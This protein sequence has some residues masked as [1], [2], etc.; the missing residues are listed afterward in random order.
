[1]KEPTLV[2]GYIMPTELWAQNICIKPNSNV[3]WEDCS[4]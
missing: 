2:A 4:A 3:K 1:V